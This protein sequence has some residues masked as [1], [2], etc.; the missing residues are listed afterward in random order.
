MKRKGMTGILTAE[1]AVCIVFSLAQ[2]NASGAFSGLA[3]FPFEQTGY[4]LR[5]LSLSGSV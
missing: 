1:A 5:V 4:A 3:A 2:V